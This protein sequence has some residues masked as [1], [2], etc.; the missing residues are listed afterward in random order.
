LVIDCDRAIV[1]LV[2]ETGTT[3]RP[4]AVTGY[5]AEIETRLRG[6]EVSVPEVRSRGTDLSFRTQ[7]SDGYDPIAALQR[8]SGSLLIASFPIKLDHE[9]LG[10]I[11]VD[12]TERPERLQS[13]TD[14]ELR[15]RGLAGQAAIAITNA[16]LID[17]IRHQ[18]LHDHLTGLPNR[19]SRG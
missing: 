11:T 15:L 8:D 5:D 7:R 9:F 4:V 6:L 1:T 16:R 19:L 2:D 18:A 13:S 14:L 10:W 3:A 17:E 12:V